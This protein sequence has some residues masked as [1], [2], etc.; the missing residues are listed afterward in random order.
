MITSISIDTHD[1]QYF[2]QD[3]RVV[4]APSV[5]VWRGKAHRHTFDNNLLASMRWVQRYIAKSVG[6]VQVKSPN[7]AT[8]YHNVNPMYTNGYTYHG[9]FLTF[10]VLPDWN[11]KITISN[12]GRKVALERLGGLEKGSPKWNLEIMSLE[13]DLFEYALCNGWTLDPYDDGRWFISLDASIGDDGRFDV[14]PGDL[15]WSYNYYAFNFVGE[16]LIE[17]GFVLF[18]PYYF[19]ENTLNDQRY[20]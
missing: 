18:D 4:Y 9:G 2:G 8:W 17:K 19:G 11:L 6:A 13:L 14:H 7:R 15:G 5:I 12:E 10:G 20:I 1:F 3:S 16:A